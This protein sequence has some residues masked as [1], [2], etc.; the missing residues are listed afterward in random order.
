MSIS[1]SCDL[2]V[3]LHQ[4]VLKWSDGGGKMVLT[5]EEISRSEHLVCSPPVFEALQVP[6]KLVKVN[7]ALLKNVGFLC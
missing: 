4:M 7:E 1:W 2:T 6:K 3:S 5:I